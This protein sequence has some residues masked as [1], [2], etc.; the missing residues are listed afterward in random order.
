[1]ASLGSNGLFHASSSGQCLPSET[2]H[3]LLFGYDPRYFPGRGLLEAVGDD[4]PFHDDDI[5]SLAHLSSIEWQDGL[6]ILTQGRKETKGTAEEMGQLFSTISSYQKGKISFRLHQ[7]RLNDAIL[8]VSGPVSPYISDSD[9]MVLGRT[10][11]QVQPLQGN[12]EPM[13]A[14]STAQAVNS[15]LTHC[16]RR[17]SDHPLNRLRREKGYPEANFLATQRTGRRIEQEP[18]QKRWGLKGVV[19]ASPSVYL[20]LA[21]EL[22]LTPWSICDHD[23]PEKDLKNKIQIALTDE[24]HD[25]FHIHTKAPDE[26]AHTGDPMKKVD[27][28]TSLDRGVADLVEAAETTNDLLIAVTADHSTP[29][30]SSLIHSGEPVPLTLVGPDVRR[31]QVETFDEIS[32]ATGCLGFLKG[33]ELMEM[34]VNYSHRSALIGHRLGP[35]E[36]AYYPDDYKPFKLSD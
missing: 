26:A 10:M 28:I 36:R 24:D 34:L 32:A 18:F 2:A 12:P 21:R 27:A 19:M 7:T 25:F 16:H 14:E 29:S 15:Y 11:A 17:L 6:P 30:V 35:V 20:G 4:I 3:Y 8:V 1:L 9:P 23:D 31:D 22:G 5:L 33:A 13:E